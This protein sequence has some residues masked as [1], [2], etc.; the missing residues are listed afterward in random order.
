MTKSLY[1]DLVI[2]QKSV[3]LI[4]D[5]YQL[6]DLLPSS[7]E[8]NLK[9][10]LKRAVVPIGLNIAGGKSRKTSRDFANFL[11]MSVPSLAE[12]EAILEICEELGYLESNN[13]TYSKIEELAK[14]INAFKKRLL[15]KK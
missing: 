15:S 12:V 8:Y 14:M 13:G 9:Q 7:E 11:N 4:T 1:K 2:W 6:S 3:D 5:V 10:Q